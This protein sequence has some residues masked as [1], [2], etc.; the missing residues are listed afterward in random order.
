MKPVECC[1]SQVMGIRVVAEAGIGQIV[2]PQ[3]K[4]KN[5]WLSVAFLESI[6]VPTEPDS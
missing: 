5:I 1:G 6:P 3:G 2:L 4:K